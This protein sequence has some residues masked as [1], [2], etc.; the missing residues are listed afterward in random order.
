MNLSRFNRNEK[1]PD[2]FKKSKKKQSI[3]DLTIIKDNPCR[4]C[5]RFCRSIEQ[6]FIYLIDNFHVFQL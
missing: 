6:Y 5:H 4:F 1:F 2:T 3:V